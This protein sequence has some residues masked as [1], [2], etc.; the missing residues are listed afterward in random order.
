MRPGEE[1]LQCSDLAAGVPATLGQEQQIKSLV[2]DNVKPRILS[3]S[4]S[5]NPIMSSIYFELMWILP[6]SFLFVK[7]WGLTAELK[8]DN[9]CFSNC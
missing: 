1:M 7:K 2:T 6:E 8:L 3:S 5:F 4:F 9:I